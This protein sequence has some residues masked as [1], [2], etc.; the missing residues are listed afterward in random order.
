MLSRETV[1][2]RVRRC[3][4]LSF[5]PSSPSSSSSSDSCAA[6]GRSDC[7]GMV[8]DAWQVSDGHHVIVDAA[9]TVDMTTRIFLLNTLAAAW[10]SM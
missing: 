10:I 4:G 3:G 2:E 5:V 8:N 7:H 1:V 6:P 9:L